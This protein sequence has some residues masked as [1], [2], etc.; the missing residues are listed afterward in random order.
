[1]SSRV[2]QFSLRLLSLR[3]NDGTSPCSGES[4]LKGG[5]KCDHGSIKTIFMLSTT[6]C[7]W[8][9]Q[10]RKELLSLWLKPHTIP[11][12]DVWPSLVAS[13]IW[14]NAL[15]PKPLSYEKSVFSSCSILCGF[16]FFSA[17]CGTRT[18]AYDSVIMSSPHRN[19]GSPLSTSTHRTIPHSVRPAWTHGSAAACWW[20]QVPE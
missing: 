14:T 9:F 7:V 13:L 12:R 4:R 19:G 11:S 8:R 20:R 17:E 10:T 3:S 18:Y 6:R 16:S 15:A 1:M 2:V 5:S